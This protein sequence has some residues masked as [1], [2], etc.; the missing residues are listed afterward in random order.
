MWVVVV[1]LLALGC[2]YC[3]LINQS[4]QL[5]N[6]RWVKSYFPN[7]QLLVRLHPFGVS[8]FRCGAWLYL[9]DWNEIKLVTFQRK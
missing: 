4:L 5:A 8:Q 6:R 3:I 1:L 2:D 9:F 7:L